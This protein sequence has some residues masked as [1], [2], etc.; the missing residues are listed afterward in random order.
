MVQEERA[1]LMTDHKLRRNNSQQMSREG[2]RSSMEGEG[3]AERGKL[4]VALGRVNVLAEGVQVGEEERV[5][6]IHRLL[7]SLSK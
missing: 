5:E 6:A 4:K 1:K 7:E 2:R 3:R